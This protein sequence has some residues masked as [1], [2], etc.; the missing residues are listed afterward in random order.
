MIEPV[1]KGR[2]DTRK[3]YRTAPPPPPQEEMKMV[4][5]TH[6]PFGGIFVRVGFGGAGGGGAWH[7]TLISFVFWGWWLRGET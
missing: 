3:L 7:V 2:S 5:P 1:N 6:W 4:E